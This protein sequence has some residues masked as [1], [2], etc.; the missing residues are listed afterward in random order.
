MSNNSSS[1]QKRP[2]VH[3][4]TMNDMPPIVCPFCEAE[5]QATAHTCAQCGQS[6]IRVC[7]R[8]N[9]IN[10]VTN[11]NCLTCGQRLDALG[12]IIAR[13]EIRLADR[14]TR[15]AEGAINMKV[16]ERAQDQ[17]RSNQLWERERL[18]QAGLIEQKRRQ[19]T[20]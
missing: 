2:S 12:Q 19:K 16:Q 7:P 20:E 18:R 4:Y 17:A 9:T 10:A 5:N 11:E 14:F 8:C 1:I 3:R 15:Q 6:L 13:H